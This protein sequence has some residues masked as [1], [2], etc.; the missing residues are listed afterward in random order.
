[1]VEG[2]EQ[3][4]QQ[5]VKSL[6]SNRFETIAVVKN[7]EEAV[8]KVISMISENATVGTGG[9]MTINQTGLRE[10]LIERGNIKPF[11][12]GQAPGNT[13][14]PLPDVFLTSSNAV[15]LDGKIINID[16]T[17]NRVSQMIY[18]PGKVI[19]VIGQNKITENEAEAVEIIQ[20]LISPFHGKTMKIDAPCAKDGKCH[21]CK[22]A[23]R[24]CN[25]TTI[26]RKKPKMTDL[27]IVLVSED[28]GLGWNP[29]WSEERINKIKTG[30]EQQWQKEMSRFRPP[31]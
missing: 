7:K 11:I 8:N 17:G 10:K 21:D 19:L 18:G 26:I 9:S 29:G 25:I 12:P 24:I 28:L 31:R 1:M 3:D 2:N 22:T 14:P 20:Q 16:A 30:Y 15:T 6:K 27:C 23:G 4:I 5:V 13:R